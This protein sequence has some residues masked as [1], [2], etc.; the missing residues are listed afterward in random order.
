MPLRIVKN[1]A[2]GLIVQRCAKSIKTAMDKQ[3]PT[4]KN[5]VKPT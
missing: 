1:I 2:K 3:R 4:K 5:A